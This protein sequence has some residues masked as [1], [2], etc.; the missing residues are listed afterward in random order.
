[1]YTVTSPPLRRLPEQRDQ[2]V[3]E[4]R[5]PASAQDGRFVIWPGRY[6]EPQQMSS[7][8]AGRTG[9]T[10]SRIPTNRPVVAIPES[11]GLWNRQSSSCRRSELTGM[12]FSPM[13]HVVVERLDVLHH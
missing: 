5:G 11:S 8:C 13:E 2:C 6:P 10:T 12:T 4:H 7:R 3:A 1:M 9:S